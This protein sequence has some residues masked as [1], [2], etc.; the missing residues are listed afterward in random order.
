M[1]D[2]HRKSPPRPVRDRAYW[3]MMARRFAVAAVAV[4]SVYVA[5]IGIAPFLISN[6]MVRSSM[7]QAVAQWTGHD[8]DIEETPEIQF[9]PEPRITLSKVTI[10]KRGEGAPE[11]IARIDKLSA[12]FGFYDALAGEPVFHDF[13]FQRPEIFVDRDESGTLDWSSEGLLSAAVRAVQPREGD[14]QILDKGLDARIGTVTVEEGLVRLDD[15][16][17]GRTFTFGGISADISWPRLS[18]EIK[19]YLIVRVGGTDIRVDVA[20]RQPLMLLA[21]RSAITVASFRSEPL[22]GRFQGLANIAGGY[23]LSGSLELNSADLPALASWTGIRLPDV[24]PLKKGSLRAELTTVGSN[25]RLGDLNFTLNDVSATGIL[26][27]ARPGESKPKLSGTLAFDKLDIG[28]LLGAL[29]LHLPSVAPTAG[30]DGSELLSVMDFDLSL[31]AGEAALNPFMLKDVA[32][33]FLTRGGRASFDIADS[34]FEDGRLTGHLDGIGDGFDDG[35]NLRISAKNVDLE[36]IAKRLGIEGP[37]PRA[38]G[39]LEL[40]L[41]SQFPFWATRVKDLKGSL[42]LRAGAGRL[43]TASLAEIVKIARDRAYFRLNDAGNDGIDFSRIDITAKF[44]EGAAEI[45]QAELE[46]ATEKLSLSGVIPYASNSLALS[47]R[48]APIASPPDA[49]VDPLRFFIGG[50]WPDPII[51]PILPPQKL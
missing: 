39:A 35:G 47:G 17:S 26:E 43:P 12:T 16:R 11:V 38:R 27:V 4:L 18:D 34:V 32:A 20:S 8:V 29:S 9:W 51:S 6:T 36:S 30:A 49:P 15:R 37:M 25:L 46:T 44:A 40:T 24:K 5:F 10:S 48:L 19:A 33:S 31:S 45:E 42:R 1:I 22:T 2:K 7:E 14:G 50:S 41:N 21:G 28:A 13:R 3:M 23:F